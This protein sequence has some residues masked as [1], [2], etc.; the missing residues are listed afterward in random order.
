MM[1]GINIDE[2]FSLQNKRDSLIV[3]LT[4]LDQIELELQQIY[5]SKKNTQD[6]SVQTLLSLKQQTEALR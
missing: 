3:E 4:K 1:M 5:N 6:E 2:L